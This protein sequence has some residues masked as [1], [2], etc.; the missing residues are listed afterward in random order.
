MF[1]MITKMLKIA[2]IDTETSHQQNIHAQ[3]AGE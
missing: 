3:E 2:F 1:T